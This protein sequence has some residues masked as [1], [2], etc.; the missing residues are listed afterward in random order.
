MIHTS[1]IELQ[2]SA[3]IKNIQYLKNIIGDNVQFVSVVKGNAYG[4]GIECFV[5]LAESCGVDFFAVFDVF[6][7]QKVYEAKKKNSKLMIMGFIDE[8]ELAWVIENGV[9]FFVFD[10]KRLSHAI[11]LAKKLKKKAKIHLEVETGLHRTGF[12]RYELPY[13]LKVIKKNADYLSFEGVCTHF[14][15]PESIANYVRI[16]KQIENFNKIKI[17]FEENNCTP[18]YFHTACS[19][20]TLMY[21]ETRMNMV[22]IGIAQYGFWPSEET[23]IH[24]LLTDNTRYKK[25]PLKPMLS[26]K[27]RVLSIKDVPVGEFIGYGTAYQAIK[28][29]LIATVPVGYYH[30]YRRSL[31]NVGYV[32]IKGK[33]SPII[34]MVNMSVMICDVTNNGHVV[35]GDEVVLI[36][37]QGRNSISVASFS[38]QLNLVNYELLTRLPMQIPRIV[39]A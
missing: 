33:K 13:V 2:K 7:A 16:H 6:E 28:K 11:S 34:G 38:D 26:W 32:L 27:S 8:H 31:S 25:D 24:N 30:G 14:A 10:R 21:P 15:G 36:G 39:I 23:R 35:P 3:L 12:E 29:T 22:R 18:A 4:H 1:Y 17:W 37:K 19:A 20:A 5:P 9:S